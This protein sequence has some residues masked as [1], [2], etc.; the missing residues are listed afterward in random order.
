[1]KFLF[2]LLRLNIDFFKKIYNQMAN[3]NCTR[4]RG[5]GSYEES[6]NCGW[7]KVVDCLDHFGRQCMN[8]GGSGKRKVSC[9]C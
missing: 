3:P 7:M 4:C 6:C 2:N 1:M 8:C 9:F 5:F